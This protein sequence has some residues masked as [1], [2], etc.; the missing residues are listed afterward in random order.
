MTQTPFQKATMLAIPAYRAA[1]KLL[2]TR[3]ERDALRDT[4]AT[5]IA[6]DYLDEIGAF[7]EL[8][9]KRAA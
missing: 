2:H 1:L 3:E 9:G 7:D 6:A 4:L 8:N 5:A